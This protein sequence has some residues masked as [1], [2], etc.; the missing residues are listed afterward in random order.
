MDE[1]L[2]NIL[3]KHDTVPDLVD[4]KIEDTLN[5]LRRNTIDETTGKYKSCE[6][7]S[8]IRPALSSGCRH[9]LRRQIL[10]AAAACVIFVCISAAAVEKGL[11]EDWLSWL[12]TNRTVV[13]EK[14]TTDISAD[15]ADN[16]PLLS[17]QSLYIDGSNL[18]FDAAL[19]ENA[20]VHPCAAKDH[21]IVNGTD[22]L[23]EYF[24][25]D[26]DFPG[27]YSCLVNLSMHT[28]DAGPD[29]TG[30]E[31][32]VDLLLY[33][34]NSDEILPF[35]FTVPLPEGL[36]MVKHHE[37]LL[38]V[39]IS[40]PDG[41]TAVVKRLDTTSTK[42][43]LDI[44]YQ[45]IGKDAEEHLKSYIFRPV[46]RD[47]NDLEV[48]NSPA[49]TYGYS[50]IIKTENSCESTWRLISSCFPFDSDTITIVPAVWQ[51]DSEGKC[52]PDSRTIL[53]EKAFSLNLK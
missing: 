12:G 45:F 40:L 1:M 50:P 11:L 18:Y 25:E 43:I 30:A 17:I 21:I 26:P 29:L 6:E 10:V 9:F 4:K 53:E 49:S 8:E 51:Y 44:H 48:E 32:T 42:L 47:M 38:D 20:D 36:E 39:P 7:S 28:G 37:T 31:V 23:N 27:S 19:N 13:E 33:L 35:S 22:C 5:Y 34:E 3:A 46:I 16:T 52:I 41:G 2:K 14:L 15:Y 24:R